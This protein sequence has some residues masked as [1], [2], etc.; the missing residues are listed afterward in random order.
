M[1][2]QGCDLSSSQG[3]LTVDNFSA[4]SKLYSFAMLECGIGNDAK[5]SVYEANKQGCSDSGIK[6]LPYHF[7][8]PLQNAPN[9]IN[10]DPVK[11]ATWHY[12]MCNSYAAFDLEWPEQANWSQWNV[13]AAFITDWTMKYMQRYKDLCGKFPLLYTYPYYAQCLGLAN[14]QEF[15]QFDL[16]IASYQDTTPLIPSPWTTYKMWQYSSHGV[17]VNGAPLDLDIVGDLTLFD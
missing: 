2:Y 4:M 15:A 7:G 1:S 16:W 11:Q 10:R 12:A 14:L 13:S 8:Y 9:H 3:I 17:L 6:V 5:S